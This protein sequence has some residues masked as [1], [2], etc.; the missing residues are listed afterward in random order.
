MEKRVTDRSVY[1]ASALFAVSWPVATALLAIFKDIN[2]GWRILIGLVPVCLM[3]YLIVLCFRYGVWQ[4]EVQKRII[5]EGLAI[6]FAVALP[7]IFLVGVLMTA[8]VK[9]PFK[10]IDS[11]YFMDVAFLIGYTIA[12]RRYQ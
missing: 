6:A 2:L 1:I 4:D 8:G 9:M 3:V 5:L 11:I 10:F 7:V 12:Y